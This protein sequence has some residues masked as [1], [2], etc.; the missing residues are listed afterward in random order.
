VKPPEGPGHVF[1][2]RG[3]LYALVQSR[4]TPD[5]GTEAMAYR[6]YSDS[7]ARQGSSE[8]HFYVPISVRPGSTA[9]PNEKRRI[10]RMRRKHEVETLQAVILD[11]GR[12]GVEQVID[13][14]QVDGGTGLCIRQGGE[15]Y[16]GNK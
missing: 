10:R 1:D 14:P 3:M 15:A 11:V 5:S 4:I 9:N 6:G 8:V 16:E 12:V 13:T 7:F 2:M